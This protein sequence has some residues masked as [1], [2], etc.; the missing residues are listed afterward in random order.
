M[1][2]RGS[3]IFAYTV[4]YGDRAYLKK[5]VTNMRGTAGVWFDWGVWLG[6]PSEGLQ[7][8]AQDLLEH[9]QR[10]GIQRLRIWPENRG[11]HHATKEALEYARE[12]G[13]KWLLRMDD[14]CQS[15]TKRWLKKMLAQLAALKLAAKDPQDRVIV[16][17][18]VVGLRH[19][20]R[21]TGYINLGQ[22]V[23]GKEFQAED[24]EVLGGV[25]RLHPVEF[26]KDYKPLLYAP[27]GR[28]DPGSI[29]AYVREHE[30]LLIRFPGIRVVHRTD[31]LEA[32]ETEN[33]GLMRKMS[34]YWPWLGG[35]DESREHV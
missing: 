17:P 27:A 11:Q 30:G 16:A 2:E 15:K 10:L 20:L 31:V 28:E 3:D 22:T 14:D 9:P 34:H 19:P 24:M 8:E 5:T 4:S 26:L 25:C 1:P 13:Y 18:K 21:A 12:K 32:N 33:Q 23:D 7:A 6:A 35:D 29:A